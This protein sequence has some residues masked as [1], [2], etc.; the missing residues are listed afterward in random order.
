MNHKNLFSIDDNYQFEIPVLKFRI[1]V[2]FLKR[3]LCTDFKLRPQ[4]QYRTRESVA[5][6]PWPNLTGVTR[7]S[8]QFLL[9][10]AGLR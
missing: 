8:F 2:F 3:I 4:F 6:E 5:V 7:S 10:S 1:D 9:A